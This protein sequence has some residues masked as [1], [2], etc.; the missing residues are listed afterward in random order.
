MKYFTK[1]AKIITDTQITSKRQKGLGF[2]AAVGSPDA[3][4]I[5]KRPGRSL[6]PKKYDTLVDEHIL[7][8][9]S[10][11]VDSFKKLR[12]QP[13]VDF[14][15]NKLKERGGY[16]SRIQYRA[17]KPLLFG[18]KK[19]KKAADNP[20]KKLT[21]MAK[22]PG[23]TDLQATQ[24]AVGGFSRTGNRPLKTYNRYRDNKHFN[25]DGVGK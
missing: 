23:Y 15:A 18:R 13:K 19:F 25:V 2:E 10:S 7:R 12:G 16:D 6:D 1:I 3:V 21:V 20:I 9:D 24:T 14:L 8:I 5:H 11:E 17:S 22:G 4:V